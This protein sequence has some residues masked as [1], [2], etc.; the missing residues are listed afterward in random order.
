MIDCGGLSDPANGQVTI[1]PG[2]VD[3]TGVG[4]TATYTCNSSTGYMLVGTAMRTCQDS[5]Q[6]SGMAPTCIRKCN[7]FLSICAEC[8]GIHFII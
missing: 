6:W 8:A 5:G 7:L 3:L 1:S 4:A 2:L